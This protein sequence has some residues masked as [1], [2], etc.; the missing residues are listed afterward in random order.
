M[1]FKYI[2]ERI[3]HES[4]L[5]MKSICTEIYTKV[6]EYQTLVKLVLTYVMKTFNVMNTP[7]FGGSR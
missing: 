6:Y 2:T 5:R 7:V 3:Q 4:V 1:N